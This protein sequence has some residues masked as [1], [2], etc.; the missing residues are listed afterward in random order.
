MKTT[1]I[2]TDVSKLKKQQLKSYVDQ[3]VALVEMQD[4]EALHIDVMCDKLKALEPEFS[5]LDVKYGGSYSETAL[6]KVVDSDINNV[7]RAIALQV[8]AAERMQYVVKAVELEMVKKFVARYIKTAIPELL[9]ATVN[10]CNSMLN[11]LNANEA[12]LAAVVKTGLKLHFDEV[13]RLLDEEYRLRTSLLAKTTL[14]EKSITVNLRKQVTVATSNLLKAIEVERVKYPELNY[15]P[16]VNGLNALNM[17]YRTT[18]KARETRSKNES[19]VENEATATLSAKTE[20][21]VA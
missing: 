20:V 3:T 4:A 13:K 1:L 8:K 7:L 11:E 6:L 2:K 18:L 16:L 10:I 15:E 9:D 19:L 17:R 5:R 12:L 14:R 21:A